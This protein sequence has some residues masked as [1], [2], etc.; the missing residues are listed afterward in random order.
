MEEALR[1]CRMVLVRPSLSANIGATARVMRNFGLADLWLVQPHADQQN[2]EARKLSTH[3]EA[4]LHTA[5]SVTSFGEAIRDCVF[6]LGTSARIGGLFRD[7]VVVTPAEAMRHAM[8]AAGSGPVALV[9][10][11]EKDGLTNE[12]IT[13]CNYLISIPAADEYPTLNLAQSVA[14]CAYELFQAC[15]SQIEPSVKRDIASVETQE[16]M[17]DL[18]RQS[19]LDLEFLWGEKAESLMHA[20]RHL[21][22]RAQPSPMEVNVLIG[23]ARQIEWYVKEHEM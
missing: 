4:I 14:I 2:E 23:L 1:R 21:I 19:L 16:R 22:G 5:R 3:G 17:F 11:P 13:R 6:T 8:D 12:E 15:R 10:G 9:F 7:Q 18:L 20:V